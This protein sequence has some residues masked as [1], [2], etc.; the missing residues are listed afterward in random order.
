ME[1]NRSTELCTH[2]SRHRLGWRAATSIEHVAA[3]TVLDL[4][5]PLWNR[6]SCFDVWR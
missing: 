1:A 5:N 2:T 4:P 3:A 6:T